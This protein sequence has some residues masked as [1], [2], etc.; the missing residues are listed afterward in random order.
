MFC[1]SIEPETSGVKCY[2]D[3][4]TD[5]GRIEYRLDKGYVSY[6][7]GIVLLIVTVLVKQSLVELPHPSGVHGFE[8]HLPRMNHIPRVRRPEFSSIWETDGRGWT[9]GV[10]P[11]P[12]VFR[13]PAGEVTSA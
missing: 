5:T 13:R 10:R 2:T 12:G 9:T 7:G 11:L 8:P 1:A 6:R 3:A 4:A